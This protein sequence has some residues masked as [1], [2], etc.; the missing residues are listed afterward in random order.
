MERSKKGRTRSSRRQRRRSQRI[1]ISVTFAVAFVNFVFALFA[2]AQQSA[3]N[4]SSGSTQ[5]LTFSA[6]T[7]LVVETV[8]VTDKKGS[9]VEGLTAKDFTVTENG[10]PQSIRIFDSQKLPDAPITTPIQR[11]EPE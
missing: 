4:A 3:Q 9:P 5:T 8:T 11:S 1:Q 2:A 6:G 10:V 7:Q